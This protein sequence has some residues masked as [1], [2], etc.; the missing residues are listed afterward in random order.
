MNSKID[1]KEFTKQLNR[2]LIRYNFIKNNIGNCQ[3]DLVLID[4]FSRM[5]GEKYKKEDFMKKIINKNFY[6]KICANR[7]IQ[8]IWNFIYNTESLESLENIINKLNKRSRFYV[9]RNIIT[10]KLEE[11]S[12]IKSS[13]S[14]IEDIIKDEKDK[15]EFIENKREIETYSFENFKF[16]YDIYERILNQA[17][18]HIK[19]NHEN[20]EK[21]IISEEILKK[22]EN[23]YTEKDI[24]L[25]DKK[26]FNK[27][28]S[29]MKN[30]VKKS[31]SNI[32]HKLNDKEYSFAV[33]Y[34]MSLNDNK[35][36]KKY[37]EKIVVTGKNNKKIE[38]NIISIP[39]SEI[40]SKLLKSV[41]CYDYNSE[42]AMNL[43]LTKVE[44]GNG[45]KKKKLFSGIRFANSRGKEEA[46]RDL[47]LATLYDQ[48]PDFMDPISKDYKD[49]Y[50]INISN[51]QLM[52]PLINTGLNLDNNMPFEQ[53]EILEKYEDKIFQF[54]VPIESEDGFTRN[55]IRKITVKIKN[56][57]LFNF[58]V[59]KMHYRANKMF[60]SKRSKDMNQKSLENLFGKKIFE[61]LS[62]KT[63]DLEY[64]KLE[65]LSGKYN[66]IIN[67]IQDSDIEI[68]LCDIESKI[69]K[70][71]IINLSKQIIAMWIIT[72]GQGDESNPTA[73]P[74][75][76]S[77]LM[78]WLGYGVSFNCKSGKDRTGVVAAEINNLAL[79]IEA[80]GEI[81]EPYEELNFK[82]KLQLMQ[83]YDASKAN[84]IAQANTGFDGLK[85]SYKPMVERVGKVVGAS[86]NAKT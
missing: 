4:I 65:S 46:I 61:T 75:R 34:R 18:E 3:N 40:N 63:R 54:S 29:E 84:S 32:E 73:L 86:K 24:R 79:D 76:M 51:V 66:Y 42:H 85:V 59:N 12:E 9:Y 70:T 74:T 80:N 17:N 83:V 31:V 57:I 60:A 35:N 14:N 81:P 72:D 26:F 13:E 25:L 71:N 55:S 82:Q 21:F 78:Y 11:L 44:T 52:T 49:F 43:W 56:I 30:L 58:G 23:M 19:N 50:E 37:E 64:K 69:N 77:L 48:Y 6:N 28:V 47:I 22:Y 68:R 8:L 53:A 41:N 16:V 45:D 67:S 20:Q 5:L 1:L 10:K 39:A 38:A 27:T 33:F 62:N 36:W 7:V 2:L 15:I